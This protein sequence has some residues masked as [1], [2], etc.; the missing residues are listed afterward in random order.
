MTNIVNTSVVQNDNKEV[1]ELLCAEDIQYRK[2]ISEGF[3][4]F[5]FFAKGLKNVD[6]EAIENP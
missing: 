5:E 4:I 6:L 2:L 1:V 3:D